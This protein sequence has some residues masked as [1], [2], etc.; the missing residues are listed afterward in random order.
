MMHLTRNVLISGMIALAALTARAYD[1]GDW[2]FWNTDSV[3]YKIN[4]QLKA[5]AETEFYFGDDMGEWYYR[6]ID[7]GLSYKATDW[8]ELGANYRYLQEKKSDEWMDENRPHGNATL[9]GTLGPVTLSDRNRFEYRIR[10]AADD[11]WRYRNRFR[12]SAAKG[13]TRFQ[14]QPYVDDEVFYD[15]N[16]HERNQ[17]RVSAGVVTRWASMFKTE[18][19]Y[20]LQSSKKSGEWNDTN[21]LGLNLKFAF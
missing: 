13:W 5:K 3:E 14:L 17:N 12:V 19:Y 11:F 9:S 2:Q 15:F 7:L 20:M 8:L 21:I 16:E 18:L 4:K 6:H 10:E 1:N